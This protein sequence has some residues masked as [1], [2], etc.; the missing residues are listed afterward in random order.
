MQ[1]V[2]FDFQLILL[3]NGMQGTEGIKGIWL[4]GYMRN[5]H[6]SSSTLDT[7]YSSLRVLQL[8]DVKNVSGKC[9][10]KFEKLVF[11]K[12]E[13]TELPFDVSKSEQLT[14]FCYKSGKLRLQPK[15]SDF[16]SPFN[17]LET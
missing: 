15:A 4:S 7:M 3:P 12:A 17:F 14:Y 8:G 5:A 9:T 1:D 6:I 11:F 2:C 16:I 10:E 13:I